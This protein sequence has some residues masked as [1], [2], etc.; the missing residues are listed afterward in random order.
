MEEMKQA[1]IELNQATEEHKETERITEAA[2]SR[3]CTALNRLN[4][5]QKRVDDLVSV[6]KKGAPRDSDW[7]RVGRNAVP[8]S[9]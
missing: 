5:A 8:V 7:G 1:L 9:Q 6:M 4:A 2:R 3:E